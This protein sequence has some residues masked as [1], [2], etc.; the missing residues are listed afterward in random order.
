MTK[1]KVSNSDTTA[2]PYSFD[3]ANLAFSSKKPINA[4]NATFIAAPRKL[5]IRRFTELVKTYLPKGNIVLGIAKESYILGFEGQPHFLTLVP[6]DVQSIIDKVNASSSASK[7]YML[8]YFQRETDYL[9]NKLT[10]KQTIFINGSWQYAFHTRQTYYT[11][12]NNGRNYKLVSTFVNEAEARHYEAEQAERIKQ[13]FPLPE[14]GHSGNEAEM[15]HFAEVA[16]KYSYDY[17]FQTGLTLAKK[18]G[19]GDYSFMLASYNKVV[20]FQTYAMLH[21]AARE[22]NFSPPHDLNHYDTVHAEVELLIKAV[23]KRLDLSETTVFINLLP[24]PPCS[25][26]LCDTDID[27]VV[28]RQDHSDG[29]AVRILEQAGKKVRRVIP[30]PGLN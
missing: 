9:I 23:E 8:H 27:E 10:F 11:L 19:K 30:E 4:L 1:R 13:S 3:W 21:G 24:C 2:T 22:V 17:N 7:I 20:P 14:E 16:A 5:S 28:Y 29:Y 6:D 12:V 15:M 18:T 25:R 26:M